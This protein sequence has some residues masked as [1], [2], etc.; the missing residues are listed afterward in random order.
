MWADSRPLSGNNTRAT[1][2]HRKARTAPPHHALGTVRHL[3]PQA[4]ELPLGPH[5]GWGGVAPEP[6]P[7]PS[8]QESLPAA[9]SEAW[10]PPGPSP[11]PQPCLLQGRLEATH[12]S[13]DL[14][15]AAVHLG[16]SRYTR[17][18]KCEYEHALFPS[19]EPRGETNVPMPACCAECR[20]LALGKKG[21]ARPGGTTAEAQAT[22]GGGSS[23]QKEQERQERPWGQRVGTVSIDH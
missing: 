16:C 8:E 2:T 19:P 13:Q 23:I 7:G 1:H 6:S 3:N 12:S 5:W 21:Q 4:P 20:G 9:A 22:G 10:A 11:P 17:L 15:K 14:S 18:W